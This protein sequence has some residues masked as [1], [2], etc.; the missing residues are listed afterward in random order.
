MRPLGLPTMARSPRT[1]SALHQRLTCFEEIYHR[2]GMV[3]IIVRNQA[4]LL[5]V[6]V[7]PHQVLHRVFDDRHQPLQR[8]PA[9]RRLHVQHHIHREALSLGDRQGIARR[10]SVRIVEDRYLCHYTCLV[11]TVP[12]AA[13][14]PRPLGAEARDQATNGGGY[15]LEDRRFG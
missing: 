5:E 8:G 4:Q 10:A 2:G 11:S 9:G 1:I 13:G 15:G 7:F 3:H 12:A 6:G 14:L